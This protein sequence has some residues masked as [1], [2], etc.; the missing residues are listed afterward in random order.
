MTKM[1]DLLTVCAMLPWLAAM[2]F[3]AEPPKPKFATEGAGVV[4]SLGQDNKVYV[5][6]GNMIVQC[7]RDGSKMVGLPAMN[8]SVAGVAASSQG[9]I[10]VAYAHF[11]KNVTLCDR[12]FNVA[13]RFTIIADASFRSPAG[14]ATGPSG[15]FYALDQGLDRV[16]RFHPDGIRCGIYRIPR[17]PADDKGELAHFRV[18]ERTN[19]IDVVNRAPAVR[20]CR[21]D[22]KSWK[23]T[24]KKLWEA[25]IEG[26]LDAGSGLFWGYGGFD[27]DENGILYVL[28]KTGSLV[29]RYDASGKPMEDVKLAFTDDLKPTDKNYLWGI[30]VSN[31]ELLLH[32]SHPTEMFQRYNLKSGEKMNIV[33]MPKDF[34]AIARAPKS[35]SEGTIIKPVKS[36]VGTPVGRKTLRVLFIGNSQLRCVSDIPEIIEEIT[37]ASTDKNV[38]VIL[39]DEIVVG[40][41]GSKGFWDDGLA[42]KRIAAGGWD[43]V[44]VHE[45]VYSYGGAAMFAEY[46]PK[47]AEA[48]KKAGAKILFVATGE[49]EQ[50]KASAGA[51]YVDAAEMAKKVGGRVAGCGISWAKAWAKDPKLDFWYT[52]RAHPSAKGYCINAC[53][54]FATL[55]DCSPVGMAV[56]SQGLDKTP[57][58]EDE[59]LL[60]QKAAWDQYQEDRKNEK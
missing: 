33:E 13:N 18:C 41:V 17:E 20:C 39:A 22:P 49:I 55:T 37:R 6:C 54:I 12:D 60:L 14:V 28:E 42:R 35:N 24:C 58:T 38:P 1:I 10:G 50:A 40:G 46:M 3:A 2:C 29:K 16:I 30:C 7:E 59:A 31:G 53:V 26:T 45:I 9:L 48:A 23:S 32:R 19:T 25:K 4:L 36:D 47:F 21:F 57:I 5:S 44:V 56:Y 8:S 43:W 52:D 27:V 11:T 34:Y 15:D 51:M